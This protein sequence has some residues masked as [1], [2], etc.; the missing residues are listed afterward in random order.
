MRTIEEH[1]NVEGVLSAI[2]IINKTVEDIRDPEYKQY[3]ND[4]ELE[5]I[6]ITLQKLKKD[7]ENEID[8]K[9]SL[10]RNLNDRKKIKNDS[11]K[12]LKL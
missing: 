10:K 2:R 11:V 6:N 9:Q 7:L 4:I 1:R 12:L 3:V 5:N 8:V